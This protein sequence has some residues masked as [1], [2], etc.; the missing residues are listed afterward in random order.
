MSNVPYKLIVEGGLLVLYKGAW[1]TEIPF[2]SDQITIGVLDPENNIYPDINLRQ[3]RL[4]G[5]DPYISRR[6]ARF[7]RSEDKYYIE[8]ICRNN[9]TSV[10]TKAEILNLQKN[11]IT[12]GA[13]I[14]I[15]ESIV[16]RFVEATL[17]TPSENISSLPISENLTTPASENLPATSENAEKNSE[18]SKISE[19]EEGMKND[20][21]LEDDVGNEIQ[22]VPPTEFFSKK[23][24]T[25]QEQL[26]KI[27]EA[28]KEAAAK[29]EAAKEA[30][31]KEAA[32][33]DPSE[34]QP[35]F[36]L[37]IET[38][39][40]IFYKSKNIFTNLIELN[41]NEWKIDS[42][43]KRA[44]HVGRHSTEDQIYPDIDLWKF[45]FNDG[46]EYIA[47]KHAR[48]FENQGKLYFQDLSG[49]GS[50]W[51]T[52][53]DDEHR[54]LHSEEDE[55]KVPLA[56]SLKL[57]ISDSVILTIRSQS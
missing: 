4:E 55:A 57:I 6:H 9:S 49:K 46:D 35:N 15:S 2:D 38:Q 30:A 45:F 16:F 44:L 51:H 21:I 28:A 53:K 10:N 33:E 34:P 13:R 18:P 50:T 26:E 23:D 41:P 39:R 29:E 31:A 36:V 17:A 48:F 37:E 8:D 47:R 5:E 12:P 54:L 3:Y 32:K 1:V 42:D 14:F 40:P 43:G 56:D 11:E 22:D 19:H 52:Q 7:L 25:S 24:S 20:E 27:E